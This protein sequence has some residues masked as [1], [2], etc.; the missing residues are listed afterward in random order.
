MRVRTK[1]QRYSIIDRSLQYRV[2]AII[3]FYCFIIV[4]FLA[5]SL[6]VPD[7]LGMMNEELGIE[8]RAVAAERVLTLHSRVWPAIIAIVCF[9]GI[10]SVRIF[11]RIIGP[12]YRFRWAFA[13]V[14]KGDLD[15]RVKLRKKDYLHKEEEAFNQMLTVLSEQCLKLQKSGM[16]AH[17]SLDALEKAVGKMSAWQD[18]DQKLLKEHRGH[19][20]NLLTDLQFFRVDGGEIRLEI[21]PDQQSKQQLLGQSPREEVHAD[22]I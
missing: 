17:K 19:V 7:I 4:L 10:H 16:D 14:S 1:R 20:R 15:F 6:F 2:L 9:V 13:K 22:A 5:I 12:L 8:V 3:L 18:A 21:G 11:H